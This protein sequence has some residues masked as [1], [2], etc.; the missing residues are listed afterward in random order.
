VQKSQWNLSE[1]STWIAYFIVQVDSETLE[2]AWL[3]SFAP[4]PEVVHPRLAIDYTWKDYRHGQYSNEWD[5]SRVSLCFTLTGDTLVQGISLPGL[6]G[7]IELPDDTLPRLNLNHGYI[8]FRSPS[9]EYYLWNEFTYYGGAMEFQEKAQRAWHTM[10]DLDLIQEL[11]RFNYQIVIY[12]YCAWQYSS[13]LRGDD[14]H[15]IIF[16]VRDRRPST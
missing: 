11:T 3:G 8:P 14:L 12:L 13:D 9:G 5:S 16:V 6:A 2:A 10:N 7:Y 1:D 15:W 4:R